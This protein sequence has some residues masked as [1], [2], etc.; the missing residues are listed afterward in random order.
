MDYERLFM[1]IRKYPKR[2]ESKVSYPAIKAPVVIK[3]V[4]IAK[5]KSGMALLITNWTKIVVKIAHL[6]KV[7]N[8][9]I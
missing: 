3:V 1:N 7:K 6:L 4:A 8:L 5:V 9:N 2:L